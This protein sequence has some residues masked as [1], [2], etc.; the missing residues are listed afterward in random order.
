MKKTKQAVRRIVRKVCTGLGLTATALTFQACYG[1]PQAMGMDV[2]I[3]GV[4]KS[5]ATNAPIKGIK[6]SAAELYQYELT[7]E[8]G[9]FQFYVPQEDVCVITF[10]D[11]DGTKNG[12]YQGKEISV[13]L[14]KN[15]ITL[16]DI[17]LNEYILL[18][19]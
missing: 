10:E 8:G 14:T 11:I 17:L 12:S 13:N 1:P 6:V 16:G 9:G 19:E 4:V 5:E 3:R 7:D 15:K 18:N 2:L